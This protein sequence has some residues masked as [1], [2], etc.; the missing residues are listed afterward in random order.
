MSISVNDFVRLALVE[1]RVARAGD[2]VN[3]DDM[4]DAL[5]IFNEL[6]DQWNAGGRT[7][8]SKSFSTVTLTPSLQPHTIGLAANSPTFSVSVGRP[9][10][11]LNAN[12]I[13]SGN[14][15]APQGGLS[16]LD[17]QQWNAISA[18]AAAGQAVTITSSIPLALWYKTG[19]PNGSIYLWP[20]PSAA[21]GLE[22]E[23]ETLLASVS[24][25]D[26]FDLPY[27]YQAALR[28]TL[29]E[30]LASAF[31]QQ[32]LPSTAR[33]AQEA[34]MAVFGNNDP[35]PLAVPDGGVPMGGTRRGGFNYMT[36]MVN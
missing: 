35:I 33:A 2:T 14:I 18:G 4:A 12:I 27:G 15:R 34:R 19:W 5:L 32:V 8:Y 31:G 36:G 20:V 6:L 24:L 28:L 11:I 7:L 17:E 23:T 1:N 9:K 29:A 13:L 26:T 21:N 10:R 22:L 25:S 16:I 3:P 30:R